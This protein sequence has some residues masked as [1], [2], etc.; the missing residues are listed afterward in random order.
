MSSVPDQK[1]ETQEVSSSLVFTPEQMHLYYTS[2][3]ACARLAITRKSL[4]QRVLAGHIRRARIIG[5]HYPGY[6]RDDVEAL[7]SRL[8]ET[9]DDAYLLPQ[10]M[11]LLQT[12]KSRV[13][14]LVKAGR[15]HTVPWERGRQKYGYVK[16]DVDALVG[17]IRSPY[18][19]TPRQAEEQAYTLLYNTLF[20]KAVR[21]M[22]ARYEMSHETAEDVVQE[23]FLDLL[24][25]SGTFFEDFSFL[26]TQIKAMHVRLA[27]AA[28]VHLKEKRT[29]ARLERELQRTTVTW[30][31]PQVKTV[32]QIVI[33]REEAQDLIDRWRQ[34]PPLQRTLI[35]LAAMG[36]TAMEIRDMLAKEEMWSMSIQTV[37]RYRAQ[38]VK[39]LHETEW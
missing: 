10:V 2:P 27:H 11:E 26:E 17:Q 33:E 37:H 34:F 4:S 5:T 24:Q 1:E 30:C 38:A 32:E 25:Y 6:L 18:D 3:Q 39:W 29:H 21:H 35:E 22:M 36:Y 12:N 7:V 15:I 14:E 19:R 28:L 16:T 8:Q 13:I 23:V 20:D 9:R 31:K